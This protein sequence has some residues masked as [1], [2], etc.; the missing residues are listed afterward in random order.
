MAGSKPLSSH[1]SKRYGAVEENK[2]L[3]TSI[4]SDDFED[5]GDDALHQQPVCKI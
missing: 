1:S 2:P 5:N 4:Q 3:L